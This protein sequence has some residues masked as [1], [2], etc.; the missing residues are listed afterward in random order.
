VARPD[1]IP[2][3][4]SCAARPVFVVTEAATSWRAMI[5]ARRAAGKVGVE[6]EGGT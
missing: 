1:E 5:Q 6:Y 2:A 4:E 3:L